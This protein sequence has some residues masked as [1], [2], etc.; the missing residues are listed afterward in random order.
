[1]ETYADKGLTNF[2]P[3][4]HEQIT[5]GL[6][7]LVIA[8]SQHKGTTEQFLRK[9]RDGVPV[10]IATQG[11]GRVPPYPDG[12]ARKYR[13]RPP[14]FEEHY[15]VLSADLLQ[16]YRTACIAAAKQ[17]SDFDVVIVVIEERFRLLPVTG[18]PYFLTKAFWLGHGI[19]VQE[20]TIE[21]MRAPDMQLQYIIN[22]IALQCYAKAGGT[23]W[24]L[25]AADALRHEIIL[26]VGQRS[27]REGRLGAVERVAGYTSLFKANGDYLLSACTPAADWDQYEEALAATIT[28]A[29]QRV[30]DHEGLQ[31]GDDVRLIFHVFKSTGRHE[32]NA[33]ATALENFRQFRIEFALLHINSDHQFLIFDKANDSKKNRLDD[34]LPQRGTIIAL[35][36]R[37]RLLQLIGPQQYR[38]RGMS[39]PLRIVLD[40]TSTFRDIDYLTDQVFGLTFMSWAGF[41][42]VSEPVTILYSQLIAGLTAQLR[43]I[44]NWN[45]DI[46][47]TKLA[48]KRWFL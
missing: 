25:R 2:G 44:P 4:S 21:K 36:E 20:V 30:I 48:E 14:K 12:F 19:S 40:R 15:F 17:Q 45:E 33:I 27:V 38:K 6:K 8:P 41:H 22:N 18:N 32:Q 7:V 31:A 10:P 11:N 35:G 23:P 1:M 42:P 34:Y 5:E 43:R 37:D 28:N 13:T 47:Q 26:G 39:T 16:S 9:L 24:V 3:Y 29:L 46:L